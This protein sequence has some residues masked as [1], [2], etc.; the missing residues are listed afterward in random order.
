MSKIT[1]AFQNKKALIPFITVGDPNL[2]TTEN[3][4]LTLQENGADLIVLG[5]PFSDPVAGGVVIQQANA[6]A[7]EAGTTTDKVFEMLEKVKEK[8]QIPVVLM[9]Y[10]NVIFVYGIQKFAER[11]KELGVVGVIIPDIPYEEKDEM[12]CV[13][14]KYKIDVIA[15]IAPGSG[16]R[17]QAITKAANGFMYCEVS[18]GAAEAILEVK[19]TKD[20]PCV[21]GMYSSAVEDVKEMAEISDG[22][23]LESAIVQIVGE[24]GKDCVPKVAEYVKKLKNELIC[25]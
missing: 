9:T 6:R 15:Q 20:I 14:S 19:K 1:E 11:A 16:E 22:V 23:I 18:S 8:L 7:L 25:S 12:D 3:I 24:H 2:E 5:I 13:F 21:I 10:A 17:I 4:I